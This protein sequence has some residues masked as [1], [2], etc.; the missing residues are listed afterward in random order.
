MFGPLPKHIRQ[1]LE[2]FFKNPSAETWDDAHSIII[3]ADGWTTFWRAV[4]AVDPSFPRSAKMDP[5]TYQTVWDT[6][7]DYFTA[8]R[9]LKYAA[10]LPKAQP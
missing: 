3:G 4:L 7:P 1:R 9:A 2:R 8:R 10:N 5:D 6:F